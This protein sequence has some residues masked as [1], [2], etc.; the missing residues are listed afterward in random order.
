VAVELVGRLGALAVVSWASIAPSLGADSQRKMFDAQPWVLEQFRKGNHPPLEWWPVTVHDAAG[1]KATYRVTNPQRLGDSSDSVIPIV[2][3]HTAEEI[4][5]WFRAF[6]PP[7]TVLDHIAAE[8]ELFDYVGQFYGRVADISAA[9]MV[10]NSR[11]LDELIRAT[12]REVGLYTGG[13]FYIP[14][15]WY[16][17]P[18]ASGLRNGA[19]TAI[20]Y[21]AHTKS[22]AGAGG[23][24]PWPSE[25]LPELLRVWQPP[26]GR[27]DL[28][29]DLKHV[30]VSQKAPHLLHPV[31]EVTTA[32]GERRE[33]DVEELARHPTLHKLI[34]KTGPIKTLRLP[35]TGGGTSWTPPAGGSSTGG[36]LIPM[37]P[38]K[39]GDGGAIDVLG[40]S[41]GAAALGLGVLYWWG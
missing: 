30:D 26:G 37:P 4:A 19:D 29:H 2:S 11:K 17:D 31:A 34:S 39:A 7:A 21:A 8:G 27:G 10:E 12:P 22:R 35:I 25:S 5:R 36:G 38:P 32:D 3:A 6:L 28:W 16:N 23:K 9:Q 24:A 14:H 15:P 33:W 41:A 18:K 1:N 20:N 13:K 40:A